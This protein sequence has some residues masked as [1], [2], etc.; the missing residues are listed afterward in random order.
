M[1]RH[2]NRRGVERV[3]RDHVTPRVQETAV[4]VANDF[5]LSEREEIVVALEIS[6]M[7]AKQPAT[8][9][10]LAE[11]VRLDHGAHRTI[12]EKDAFLEGP[13]YRV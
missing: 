3:R 12:E 5:R 4:D 2:R 13:N 10:V 8:K 6:G 11:L 1:W 7:V 9:I